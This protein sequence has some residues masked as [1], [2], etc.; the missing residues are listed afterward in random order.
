MPSYDW[1]FQVVDKPTPGREAVPLPKKY[2]PAHGIVEPTHKV[3]ALV[4]YL[5]SLKQPALPQDASAADGPA[6]V[7]LAVAARATSGAAAP[8]GGFDASKGSALFVA[9]CAACH[10]ANGEGLPGAFPSLKGDAAVNDNDATKQMHVV[11]NGLQGA[12]VGGVAYGGAMPPF[13]GRLSD[14]E[15]ADI[16]DYER[17][18]W[19]NHGAPVTAQQVAVERTKGK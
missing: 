6:P 5:M 17:T 9:N 12:T 10:Q 4:A 2:A 15:I 3:D 7:E 11:L 19:G 13:A 1:M 18:S 14:T 16:I 8:S